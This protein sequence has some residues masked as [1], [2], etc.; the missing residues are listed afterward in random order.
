MCDG[1]GQ[2]DEIILRG[3]NVNNLKNVDLTLPKNQIVV[4][5]GVS[6]SGKSSLVF[7]TI[8]VECKR[9][10]VAAFPAYLRYRMPRYERPAAEEM[11]N[12][13]AAVVIDQQPLGSNPRSTIGT[14][15]DIAPLVRLLFS[16]MGEPR[17]GAAIDF[18]YQ[19]TFG[20]CPE[21]NGLGEK[22]TVDGDAMV[23]PEKSLNDG[24]VRF[25]YFSKSNWQ[26]MYYTQSGLFDNDK[27]VKDYTAE[28]YRNLLYGPPE[29]VKVPFYLKTGT[30]YSDYEGLVPRFERLYINRDLTKYPSVSMAEVNRFL[31]KAPCGACQ[32]TGLN[33]KALSC[34]IA[35]RNIADFL[36]LQ[37][38]D[39]LPV[40]R[41]I[42]HPVGTPIALQAAEALEKV[43]DIGLG[44][45]PLSRR[46]DTL[47]G[48]E[49]KRLKIVR[50]LRS[51]LNNTTFILDEPSAGLHPHDVLQLNRLLRELRD[52]HNT[53]LVVEHNPAVIRIADM[54]VDL[55]PE[56]GR[57]GGEITYQGPVD[58]LLQ[59]GTVTAQWLKR[60]ISLERT[61]RAWSEAFWVRHARRNNLR[62][63]SV[64]IPKNAL[65]VV[66]GVA[67]SGKSTLICEEFAPHCE[68]A[69][70]IDRKPV[71]GSVRS[72]PATYTGCMDAIRALF[73]KANGVPA[74]RFSFNSEGGCPVCH[75]KGEVTP[76]VAFADPVAIPCEAC[77][78]RRYNDETLQMNYRGRN[79]LEVLGMTAREA[80]EFF[81][82]QPRIVK[83]LQAMVEVGL[84]YLTLGQSTDTLSG[85]ENQRVKLAEEL[86]KSGNA[87]ILDEPT[88]GLHL[89]DTAKLLELLQRLVDK[90]NSV[91]V[92]EHNLEVVAAADWLIDL[93]P[94][95]GS[96]GGQ[97]VFEG[98]PRQLL[99]CPHSHTADAL[100]AEM[101]GEWR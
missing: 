18:S 91:I 40:L 34:R 27:P 90:G 93:G 51:S 26:Y 70:F 12:L 86:H 59:S 63:V 101:A 20:V 73:A 48:G 15:T 62:D 52:R 97:V 98:T 95:S 92:I 45:L 4:F 75:G 89:A 71:G 7:D 82:D 61:P 54:V 42:D 29:K 3:V 55:G 32:G 39:L 46:T 60:R 94:G 21:C 19:S 79:I 88:A 56:A 85:G 66:T 99:Q 35:G 17:I 84:G 22:L 5:T 72:T 14:V 67:G 24:A 28:E 76:D 68:K 57:R 77:H 2:R 30:V 65:T 100:R 38:R 9:Q 81:A 25:R 43:V 87:Y 41:A 58:G 44:Y 16:R 53:V 13:T 49:A 10:M 31:R 74:G 33:Q 83:R 96:D 47:S 36:N 50:S 69:V 37:I 80:M 11:R 78:G 6:G 23:D 64:R 8:G 1:C